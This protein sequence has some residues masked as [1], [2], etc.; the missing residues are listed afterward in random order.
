[1]NKCNLQFILIAMFLCALAPLQAQ[2]TVT[3]INGDMLN[4]CGNG[5]YP[6]ITAIMQGEIFSVEGT[7]PAGVA[8]LRIAHQSYTDF[9]F[10]T[11]DHES[12][13][14]YPNPAAGPFSFTHTLACDAPLN[15]GASS[16]S[17]II[18]DL[19]D[20]G[21]TVT[22]RCFAY[23]SVI[24]PAFMWEEMN[25]V[26]LEGDCNRYPGDDIIL[27]LGEPFTVSGSF[28]TCEP[29]VNIR[30]RHIS[31]TDFTFNT[32]VDFSFTDFPNPSPN[33][34][35]EHI[36]PCD[37]T[38]NNGFSPPSVVSLIY[39]FAD[40]TQDVCTAYVSVVDSTN[41][42]FDNLND[43]AVPNCNAYPGITT[44]EQ[45]ETFTVDGT[46]SNPCNNI[47]TLRVRHQIYSDFT[48]SN[49]VHESLTD[50]PAPTEGAYELEHTI[51]CDSPENDGVDPPSIVSVIGL[52]N[53]GMEVSLCAAYVAISAA[54]DCDLMLI[55]AAGAAPSCPRGTDGNINIMATS[56]LGPIEYIISGEVRDT[57]NTG[58]FEN[59]PNGSYDYSISVETNCDPCILTGTIEIMDGVD[60]TPPVIN[61][62]DDTTIECSD[63]SDPAD[64]GMPVVTD[65]CD[66]DPMVT[67][68][69]VVTPGVCAS[70][71]TIVRTW[72]ATDST[73]NVA[74]C[75]QTINIED[76]TAPVAPA[77]L[78][79]VTI[80]CLVDLEPV[81]ALTALDNC[82]GTITV[83]PTSATLPG[84]C[85]SRLTIT[86]TWSFEDACGNSS[87]TSQIINVIDDQ[88]INIIAP[89]D[90]TVSCAYNV[91]PNTALVE[92]ISTCS[93]EADIT[94]SIS[95]AGT[96]DCPG[97][98]YTVTYTA[99]D[100]C[101]R[102]A[103]D[104]Q[105]FTIANEGPEFVCPTDFCEIDCP[106]DLESIQANFDNYADL[107]IVNTSCLGDVT[108]TNNFSVNGF[109][110]QNCNNGPIAVENTV[111]WQIVTF[112]ATD[113]CGRNTSCTSLVII[114][115]TTAPT[116]VGQPFSTV[117]TNGVNNQTLYDNWINANL[118][119]LSVD[120]A[121]NDFISNNQITFTPA[122]PNATLESG[123]AVT[124]VTFTVTDAC[125]NVATAKNA[126]FVLQD[127][128][129]APMATVAGTIMTDQGQFV[130][131]TS[132]TI[133][134]NIIG[135]LGY[136]T[137]EEDGSFEFSVIDNQTYQ[138]A[139]KRNDDPLNGITT[140]DLIMIGRHVLDIDLLSSPYQLIAADV[141]NSGSVTALDMIELRRMIL[142]IDEEFST[143][144]SWRFVDSEFVFSNPANPFAT[145][146]PEVRNF[147][148]LL[149][150]VAN[151]VAIK[152]GDVNA[153]AIPNQLVTAGDTRSRNDF[154][155]GVADQQFTRGEMVQVDFTA[156][157]FREMMGYQFGLGFDQ[158][159]LEFVKVTA[160][161]L[162]GLSVDNFGF[163]GLDQ[164]LLTTSWN[165]PMGQSTETLAEDQVLFTVIFK[166][167]ADNTLSAVLTTNSKAI[168]AEAYNSQ[169]QEMNVS[170]DFNR[171]LEG[172]ADGSAIL[173]QNR[174]NPFSH[175][176]VIGFEL[177]KEDHA[178]VTI[179]DVSGKVVRQISQSFQKGYHEVSLDKATLGSTGLMYYR[180]ETSNFT[181]T[182]KMIVID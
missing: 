168:A 51:A 161:D 40:G 82:D 128:A 66:T 16:P 115:D 49:L 73:G 177:G 118:A 85:P 25:G 171:T 126:T 57:N 64:T 42:T 141:N 125:G 63:S 81:Q 113:G 44:L 153:T 87:S 149:E 46:I 102:T 117:E 3:E 34:L 159:A 48:F 154:M 156:K 114:K 111:A 162:P 67:M 138:I 55:T 97:T 124:N 33:F 31:F 10:T 107:A 83:T 6:G 100:D 108:I 88:P 165:T 172:I 41:F 129:S 142:H 68:E 22:D 2:F 18:V 91:N 93:I 71:S 35:L 127:G 1:M 155:I 134:H 139:P 45:G 65:D 11:L 146:F 132:V 140:M 119:T 38:I 32:A 74:T 123:F 12:Q 179:F 19:L 136:H 27:A 104:S 69:E 59:L 26:D 14:S 167:L 75:S 8:T 98:R 131:H 170:L 166:A 79:T 28:S 70:A 39:T 72:T 152:V 54:P 56:D 151:F 90:Q 76:S 106:A 37:A 30:V 50:Y 84:S 62:P 95:I 52:D 173:Y 4:D 92:I 176:T 53:L 175:E 78:A 178:T 24:P 148:V 164:G 120:D 86:R 77:N 180:L 121:C 96:P 137:T 21:G 181:A 17:V 133:D 89:A 157:D 13:T 94:T 20:A 23:I 160:K 110:S 147:D 169:Q 15:D 9:T 60:N 101:G 36:L 109:N 135:Q 174:P 58:I 7:L 122:S 116:I 143:S 5:N 99:L 158:N 61:C 145:T 105:V 103:S 182:K 29:V 163:S 150:E 80:Q 144:Q 43:V 112:N 130:E 47:V